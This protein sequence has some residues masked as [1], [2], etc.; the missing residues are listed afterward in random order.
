MAYSLMAKEVGIEMTECMLLEENDR[1]HFMTRRFDREDGKGKIHV[2][3]FCA[4]GHM[5]FTEIAT[6]SYEQLFENMRSMH[7]PYPDAEQLYRRIV[8]NVMA[9]NWK[10][11]SIFQSCCQSWVFGMCILR[12]FRS[13]H[14]IFW[15]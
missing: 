12:H 5:D 3:S 8:F 14:L 1:A 7:M 4:L 11:K 10:K 9:K 6:F 15:D 2:Q 13:G